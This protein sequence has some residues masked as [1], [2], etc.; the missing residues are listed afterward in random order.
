MSHGLPENIFTNKYTDSSFETL[1]IKNIINDMIV[2]KKRFN[3]LH[4]YES[5]K[6]TSSQINKYVSISYL[7]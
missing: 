3:Q 2:Y 4:S 7:T 1:E 5:L 6:F